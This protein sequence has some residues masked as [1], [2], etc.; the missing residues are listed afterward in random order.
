[1]S[2]ILNQLR[3]LSAAEE[4]FGLLDVPYEQPVLNVARLH[5]LRRMRDYM[6][7][8]SLEALAE[9]E[10]HALLRDGLARAYGDFVVSAPIEQ[11]VFKVLKEAAQPVRVGFVP[12]S[13]ITGG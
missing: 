4:F 11:R 7:R 6:A 1:M 3:A 9:A 2:D 13:A 12:L 5:I 8:A 10:A